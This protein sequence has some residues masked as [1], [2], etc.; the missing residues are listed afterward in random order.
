MS[1]HVVVLFLIMIAAKAPQ[2]W[3]DVTLAVPPAIFLVGRYGTAWAGG[4]A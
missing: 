3:P 2:C 1:L 4:L